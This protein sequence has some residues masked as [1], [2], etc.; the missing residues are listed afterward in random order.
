MESNKVMAA[1]PQIAA[2]VLLL[3]LCLWI[4]APFVTLIVWPSL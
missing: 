4:V 3:G 2:V 1:F